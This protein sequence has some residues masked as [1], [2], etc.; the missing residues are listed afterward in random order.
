LPTEALTRIPVGNSAPYEVIVGT[1]AIGQTA[2]LLESAHRIAV[3]RPPVMAE[4]AAALADELRGG[5]RDVHIIE[6]PAGEAAKTPEVALRCWTRLA[7]LSFT[8]HD[9]LVGVGGGTTS[10][11]V[12]FVAATW[13]RGVPVVH[14]PTTLTAMVDAA[15]GGKTAINLPAGKN[16]VGAFHQ[17]VGVV[18]DL[19]LLDTLPEIDLLTGFAEIVRVGFIADPTILDLIDANVGAVTEPGTPQLA[20]VVERAIRVKA[21]IVTEDPNDQGRRVY[22]NYGHTLGHAIEKLE[23]YRW[24]HGSAVSVGLCY[25]A[26]LGRLTG[27]LDHATASRHVEILTKLG[28]PTIY[29]ADAWP[30]LLESM[31]VDKKRRGKSLR[32]VVLT[33]L[34]SPTVIEEPDEAFLDA[35]YAPCCRIPT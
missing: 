28:L 12:G 5:D 21:D 29:R 4:Q 22:L 17:P 11:L 33:G 1:G 31:Q 25:A 32:F 8:R 2:G 20:E 30:E 14:V 7:E 35:A 10:D 18:V 26:E 3:L 13:L 23:G 9:A 19:A 6:I 34:G 27:N 24:R 16:L 15:I